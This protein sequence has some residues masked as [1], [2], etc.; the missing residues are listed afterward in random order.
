MKLYF[1]ILQANYYKKFNLS[2][3]AAMNLPNGRTAHSTFGIPLIITQSSIS[4]VKKQS[5]KAQVLKLSRVIIW[6]EAPMSHKDS[7]HIVDNLL[8]DLM[9]SELP[10]G[11]YLLS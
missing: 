8:K 2:G 4:S 1:L 5:T 3:I 10:F 9:D 7:L 6:D 11:E